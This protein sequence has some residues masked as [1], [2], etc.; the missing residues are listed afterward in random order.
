M[1]AIRRITILFGKMPLK[2]QNYCFLKIWGGHGPVAPLWLR[3]CRRL[4]QYG[5]DSDIITAAYVINYQG[6]RTKSNFQ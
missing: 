2:A 3:L 1:F 6:M 4:W 5:T